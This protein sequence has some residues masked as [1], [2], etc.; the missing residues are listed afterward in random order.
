MN[1]F[2]EGKKIYLRPFCRID[3]PA[4]HDWFNDP[5]VTDYMN[6]GIFPNTEPLQ[7]EYLGF[8]TGSKKDLQLAI[9]L[10][11]KELLVGTAGIHKIDWIHRHG[12]LSVVIGDKRYWNEGIATQALAL[13]IRH[14][15]TKMN[16]RRLTAGVLSLN[17]N[18][19]TCFEENG[20]MLEGT[21][22]KHFFYKDSYV[23]VFI[24]GLLKEEWEIGGAK[25]RQ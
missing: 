10:K 17:K 11:E 15:F 25:C 23:D 3:I 14:A 18:S 19:R 1:K 6:K 5:V 20:F 2:L 7:E 24:F 21:K 4:W 13:I 8:L 16:L 9:I 12:D 22:R